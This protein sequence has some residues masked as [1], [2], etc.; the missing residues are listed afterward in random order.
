MP[1]VVGKSAAV[2]PIR[3]TCAGAATAGRPGNAATPT[4][5]ASSPRLE[6]VISSPLQRKCLLRCKAHATDLLILRNQ[7]DQGVGLD[8]IAERVRHRRQRG[9]VLMVVERGIPVGDEK[10][11]V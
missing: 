8:H 7:A 5:D 6:T 4:A 1:C 11:L 2:M 3:R 9:V 10:H